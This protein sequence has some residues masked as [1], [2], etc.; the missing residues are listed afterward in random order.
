MQNGLEYWALGGRDA[1]AD[2]G[3]GGADIGGGVADIGRVATFCR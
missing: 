3:G 1:R 2:I